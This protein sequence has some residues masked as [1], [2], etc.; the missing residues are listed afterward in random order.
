MGVRRC[1]GLFFFN[2]TATTEIYTL[3]LHDA[4]PISSTNWPS[5]QPT[6]STDQSARSGSVDRPPN[7]S[8]ASNHRLK[9]SRSKLNWYRSRCRSSRLRPKTW[10]EYSSNN[11][12]AGSDSWPIS[13]PPPVTTSAQMATHRR[14]SGDASLHPTPAP[15]NGTN[16]AD[17]ATQQACDQERSSRGRRR[18]QGCSRV[19]FVRSHGYSSYVLD[20]DCCHGPAALGRPGHAPGRPT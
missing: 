7:R 14:W 19:L 9:S 16:R 12:G 17:A 8:I 11:C 20:I 6:S 13:P 2:D 4:L 15:V 10:F 1:G 5:P 3:S 18:L